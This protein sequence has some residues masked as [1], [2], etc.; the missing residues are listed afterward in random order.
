MQSHHSL[1]V[2]GRLCLVGEHTD[3]AAGYRTSVPSIPVGEAIVTGVNQGLY[4][5]AQRLPPPPRTTTTP[6]AAATAVAAASCTARRCA[7]WSPTALSTSSNRARTRMRCGGGGRFQAPF[8]LA[9]LLADAQ[10]GSPF[11]YVAGCVYQVLQQHP[12]LLVDAADVDEEPSVSH[13][14]IEIVNYS[15]TLPVKKG[16]SSSAALSVLVVRS[17]SRVFGLGLSLED[18][19]DLAYLGETTTPSRCGRLDQVCGSG[20]R[21]I[22]VTFHSGRIHGQGVCVCV[23]MDRTVLT[24]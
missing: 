20:T 10:S 17:F 4:A 7:T 18:E 14:G 15:T 12:M 24:L 1:F 22:R 23:W 2:P 21:P 19:M 9:H 8:D 11:S 5:R 3:W 13:G 6:Q 16:L